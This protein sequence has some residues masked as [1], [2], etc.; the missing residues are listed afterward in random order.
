M[1]IQLESVKKIGKKIGLND[2]K[3]F[4]VAIF[5]ALIIVSATV[6]GYF[7]FLKPQPAAYNTIYLLDNQK[8]AIDY[9]VTLVANQNSTFSLWMG[10][11][12]N[13]G[14]S[15][16]QTYQ[17]LVKI[18][19]NLSNFPVTAQPIQTY[20][21]SLANG[22][23]WEKQSTI[24]LNQIGSYSVVFE[25]WHYN[26]DSNVKAYQFTNNYCVLNIQVIG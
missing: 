21:L 23:S 16:N 25:L 6:A 13:M 11:V 22:D 2:D 15:G 24:T 10:V 20:D 5:L 18:T 17:V 12:N 1:R 9:P 4:I 26:A 8:K 3:G 19:P 7:L 14:G